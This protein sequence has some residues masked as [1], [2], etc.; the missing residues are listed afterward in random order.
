M[1]REE[2][3]LKIEEIFLKNIPT[4]DKIIKR[5]EH[6]SVTLC[7]V[8]G[9]KVIGVDIQKSFIDNKTIQEIEAH[10]SERHIYHSIVNN[11]ELKMCDHDGIFTYINDPSCRDMML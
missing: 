5:K 4:I 9:D 10:L 8:I 3:V 11:H 1:N 7:L 2:K 6:K